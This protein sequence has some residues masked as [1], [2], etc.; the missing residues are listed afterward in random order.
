MLSLAETLRKRAA[1]AD[2]RDD[3]E[4]A[5]VTLTAGRYVLWVGDVAVA[6]ETDVCRDP[7][8]VGRVWTR[9][10]LH[11]A[12]RRINGVDLPAEKP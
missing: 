3:G 12:A 8:I 7:R 10:M 9:D 5:T 11:E 4:I 1:A 2:A 6:M